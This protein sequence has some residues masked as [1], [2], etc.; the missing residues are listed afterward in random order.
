MIDGVL[1]VEVSEL[2]LFGSDSFTG[3]VSVIKAIVVASDFEFSLE[4]FDGTKY[5]FLKYVVFGVRRNMAEFQAAFDD[6]SFIVGYLPSFLTEIAELFDRSALKKAP[7]KVVRGL[8]QA[9]LESPEKARLFPMFMALLVSVDGEFLIANLKSVLRALNSSILSDPD[10]VAADDFGTVLFR[11]I[12]V[13]PDAKQFVSHFDCICLKMAASLF[14]AEDAREIAEAFFT[15]LFGT[16]LDLDCI[17]ASLAS[18]YTTI[19]NTPHR[20]SA[21]AE[22]LV[23]LLGRKQVELR[24]VQTLASIM[25]PLMVMEEAECKRVAADFLALLE[26]W[27][28]S[29]RAEWLP[30]MLALMTEFASPRLN[31]VQLG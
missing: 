12:D 23:R 25:R 7:T 16:T 11:L 8:L 31:R 29:C 10:L 15:R 20:Y 24:E 14:W 21:L 22:A 13:C 18:L 2:S 3:L 6:Q 27:A 19:N 1:E 9:M 5:S 17:F 26:N 4:V 28:Q 30:A